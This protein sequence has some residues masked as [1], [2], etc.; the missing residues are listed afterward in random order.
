MDLRR[1]LNPP[2]K[3]VFKQLS[4]NTQINVVLN[5]HQGDLSFATGGQN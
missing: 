1:E 4:S 5:P 2:L 3:T